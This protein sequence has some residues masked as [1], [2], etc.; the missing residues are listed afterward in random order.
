MKTSITKIVSTRSNSTRAR[1][2]EESNSSCSGPQ[3][4][5]S[6]WG[7]S[8]CSTFS[9]VV[10]ERFP[11]VPFWPRTRATVAQAKTSSSAKSRSF[12]SAARS[13]TTRF[14]A[15]GIFP[16]FPDLVLLLLGN[17]RLR[18]VVDAQTPPTGSTLNIGKR[19]FTILYGLF[20]CAIQKLYKN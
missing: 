4:P 1:W 6:L 17:W 2:T 5:P 16:F 19:S 10:T 7:F 15:G 18:Q 8:V 9:I 3:I 20:Q 12:I 11:S 14:F 13:T